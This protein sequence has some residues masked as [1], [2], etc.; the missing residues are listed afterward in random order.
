MD[1]EFLHGRYA[2]LFRIGHNVNEMILDF[3][4]VDPDS[5]GE[6]VH[7]RIITAPAHAKLFLGLLSEAIDS[8]EQIYGPLPTQDTSD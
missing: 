1:P 4:Q 2:N 8:Y 6:A 3:G 7:T 5:T